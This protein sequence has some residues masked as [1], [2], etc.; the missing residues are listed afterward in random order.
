MALRDCMMQIHASHMLP[1]GM[2]ARVQADE[3]MTLQIHQEPPAALPVSESEVSS[4]P[5]TQECSA[6]HPLQRRSCAR[7]QRS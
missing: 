5:N 3:L 6:A 7:E 1:R 2:V 4:T